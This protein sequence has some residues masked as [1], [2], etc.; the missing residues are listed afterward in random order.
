MLDAG[1][2]PFDA[3]P[4]RPALRLS[5]TTFWGVGDA[6]TFDLPDRS[7]FEIWVRS[8]ELRDAEICRKGDAMAR[9]LV[10]GQRDG[11][12]VA[13]WQVAGVPYFLSGGPMPFDTWVHVAI[14]RRRSASGAST[15]AELYVDGALVATG[16][17]PRLVDS[18]NDLPFRCGF[19]DADVDEV[20]LWRITRTGSDILANMRRRVSGG[21][22][23]M[24]SYWRLDE[25]GQILID[26]TAMGRVGIL[27]HLTTPDPAD[28]VWI[29]DGPF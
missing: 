22:P 28:P 10:V 5:R 12:L 4:R 20:R 18:F 16:T 14:V 1:P 21:I 24:Q 23:G 11:A 3:G 26:Y 29:A 2:P 17:L 19:A 13:G 25:S 27:G 7:T 15:D 6:P 8:R 9:D